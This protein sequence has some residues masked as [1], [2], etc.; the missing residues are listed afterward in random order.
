MFVIYNEL[1]DK[2]KIVLFMSLVLVISLVSLAV[3][4]TPLNQRKK[5]NPEVLIRQLLLHLFSLGRN[6]NYPDS[7]M[8]KEQMARLLAPGV[9]PYCGIS[10]VWIYVTSR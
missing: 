8:G 6:Y 3:Q 5:F 4:N 10:L 9:K 2:R 1:S 7:P